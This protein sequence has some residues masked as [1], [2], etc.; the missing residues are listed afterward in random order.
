MNFRQY[1]DKRF[2]LGQALSW[3]WTCLVIILLGAH[4]YRASEYGIVLCTA[5]ILLLFCS[6]ASWKR[7]A[8]G[9]FLLWGMLEWSSSACSLAQMRMAM[10]MPWMRGA[11]ILSAVAVVTGLTG[12]SVTRQ[13]ARMAREQKTSDAFLRAAVF[14]SVFLGLFYIRRYAP[15][16]LLLLER[17]FPRIGAVEIFL[18]ACYG[19]FA[20]K[21]LAD[22]K[23]SR[24]AR[25]R[26]WLT[27]ACIF[28]A[29][30]FLGIAGIRQMLL[31]GELHTPIPAFIIYGAVFRESL[32]VMP[33]IVLT[34][35]LLLGSAWCSMLCYF[36][37]FDALASQGKNLRPLP[38]LLQALLCWGR[39]AVLVS[40]I[41]AVF[42]LKHM[43]LSTSSAVSLSIAYALFSLLIMTTLSRRYGSMLHCTTSC[44][45]GLMISLLGRLAPWRIKVDS[46]ACNDCSACERA[47]QWRAITPES[48]MQGKTLLRCSLCRDCIGVCHK[49]AITLRCAGLDPEISS[50]LFTGLLASLHAIFLACAMV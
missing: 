23:L 6:S 35:T 7:W 37:P 27:F 47:C 20:A 32:N 22:P 30:F 11:L 21:L 45:M 36:G 15:F 16:D 48:R 4:F 46:K 10:D 29:Q 26:L 3:L 12:L 33:F 42:L 18:A 44:P 2:S 38:K 17:F 8:V 34:S 39:I 49:K 25:I 43:G 5:G 9:L 19:S 28:F 40:G 50:Q 41:G 31:S 24:K 1:L 14:M 13:A